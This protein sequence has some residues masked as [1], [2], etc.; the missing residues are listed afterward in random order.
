MNEPR[1]PSGRTQRPK[2]NIMT[3]KLER[4]MQAVLAAD[5]A[6]VRDAIESVHWDHR[7]LLQRLVRTDR[8]A[9][10]APPAE[11]SD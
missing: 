5:Q 3:E 4:T 8:G 11:R 2:G 10:A 6:Y 7:G 9:A 1:T